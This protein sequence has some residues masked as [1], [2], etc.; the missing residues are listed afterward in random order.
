MAD[1]YYFVKFKRSIMLIT[2]FVCCR[3]QLLPPA[4]LNNTVEVEFV[5]E[6]TKYELLVTRSGPSHYHIVIND[7]SV[8]IEM[9]R[10]S[11]G[12]LLISYDGKNCWFSL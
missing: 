7:S 10:L 3:G 4:S 1:V 5:H 8:D 12:G 2:H 9:H 6:G 11:D